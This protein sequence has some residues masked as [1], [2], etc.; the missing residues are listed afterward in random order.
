MAPPSRLAR[1]F[2]FQPQPPEFAPPVT[3]GTVFKQIMLVTSGSRVTAN[4]LPGLWRH[5]SFTPAAADT[6]EY[7]QLFH[8]SPQVR[9]SGTSRQN[10]QL[11]VTSRPVASS[12]AGPVDPVLEKTR[13]CGWV[14][15]ATKVGPRCFT[16]GMAGTL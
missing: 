6:R 8:C 16:G 4:T 7:P 13:G 11:T 15:G 10:G 9:I 5:A 12:A 2:P 1:G 3:G 14:W